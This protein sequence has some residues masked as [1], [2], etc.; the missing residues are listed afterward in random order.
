MA[1][2]F[3]IRH[4]R[5]LRAILRRYRL[6]RMGHRHARRRAGLDEVLIHISGH[7]SRRRRG[8]DKV[9]LELR[10]HVQ[11]V[12]QEGKRGLWGLHKTLLR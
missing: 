4:F 2:L 8:W 3:S 6:H 7:G 12:L 10:E 1:C 11:L 5:I 9:S